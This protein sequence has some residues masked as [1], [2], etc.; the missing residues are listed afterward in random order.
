MPAAGTLTELQTV[1][2]LP[3]DFAG[4]PSAADLHL[5]PDGRFIY[6]SERT[7]STIKG[8]RIDPER[9]TFSRCGRWPTETTPR[10]FAI[11][12]RGRFLLAVGL[13]SNALTVSAIDPDSG[14][15]RRCSRNT[16]WARCRTGSRSSI[17]TEPRQ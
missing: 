5:T 6:A 8:F 1:P 14:A 10:G 7:T 3:P 17:C 9:G 13:S 16:R 11:D 12:P 2:T 4:K 15:P